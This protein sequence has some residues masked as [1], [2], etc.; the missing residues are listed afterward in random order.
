VQKQKP[1]M[2]LLLVIGLLLIPIALLG[3]LFVKQSNKDIAFA[4]KERDGI[5]YL[6][7]VTPILSKLTANPNGLS[8]EDLSKLQSA[9]K[10]FGALM[11]STPLSDQL[12]RSAR[13]TNPP[14]AESLALTHQLISQIG[15]N[16]N[17]ILDP[18][19]DSYYL[20]EASIIKL[21]ELFRLTAEISSKNNNTSQSVVSLTPATYRQLAIAGFAINAKA[22]STSVNKA[23][24][25][26][27]N[28]GIDNQLRSSL[29]HYVDDARAYAAKFL[30][31]SPLSEREMEANH[32]LDAERKQFSEATLSMWTDVT[33]NLDRLLELRIQSLQ[34]KFLFA[35]AFSTV[36]TFLA[37]G[38]AATI[39]YR[40]IGKLDEHIV[41]LAHHDAMTQLK[42]RAS[43]ATILS[44]SLAKTRDGNPGIAVHLIDVDNFKAINDTLGHQFGDNV[45]IAVADRLLASC[46]KEDEIGRLGGDEFIVLQKNVT[47]PQ[48]V[49]AMSERLVSIL[50]QPMHIEGKPFEITGSIGSAMAPLH[51]KTDEDILHC[52]D[53]ALYAAKAAGRNRANL[54][55]KALQDEV[56]IKRRLE[57]DVRSAI[58]E[59]RFFLHFQPQFDSTGKTLKGFEALLR[60]RNSSGN[61][62]SPIEFIP[63]AEKLGIIEEVGAWVLLRGAI[64]AVK[65]PEEVKL[66]VNISPLQ[67]RSGKL[68][69]TISEALR[70]SGLKSSR[71]QIEITEGIL[72]DD[73]RAVL[74]EL[75]T[76]KAMGVSIALDDF[77]SG[78]SSLSYLWRFPFDKIKIDRSFMNAY[79]AD[80]VHAESILRTI[81]ML[82][83][84]LHM[85]VTAEGVETTQQAEFLKSVACDE[86]QGFLFSKPVDETA[87]ASLLLNAYRDQQEVRNLLA[88]LAPDKPGAADQIFTRSRTSL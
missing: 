27:T 31:M 75:Q 16:S 60:M 5:L 70:Q 43:L 4:S 45:L 26:N 1:A 72:L 59:D 38:I 53:L 32:Q 14:T 74:N 61:V 86:I 22:L 84:S 62:V 30:T 77:G 11:K 21:P 49:I 71:L 73:S 34:K 50:H 40:H 6:R 44:Q 76:I 3:W 48:Q 29:N 42:N 17:L 56:E 57:Q 51:A 10:R 23:I 12:L 13:E 58:A 25:N 28:G 55:S 9:T 64:T 82:G 66:A 54:F 20:M 88:I 69:D 47:T 24:A 2:R 65:W 8:D 52:A 79:N 87:L 39:L 36:V 46:A 85:T 18:D 15:D 37:L 80:R 19:L 68:A 67:F 78:Y 7:V 33:N 81:V 83:H 63:I 35:I 41:Y